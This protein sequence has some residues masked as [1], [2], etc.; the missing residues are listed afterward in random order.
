VT[1]NEPGVYPTSIYEFVACTLLFGLLWSLR[2]HPF[3]VGWLFM[4][5][6]ALN[7]LERLAIEQIRVNNKF[8]LLGLEVTQAEVISS[9]LLVVGLAGSIWL[10]LGKRN[11]PAQA[12]GAT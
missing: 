2:K 9:L 5:Y 8:S 11:Q 12:Q 3:A 6:L 4:V 1:L 10:A 7:G